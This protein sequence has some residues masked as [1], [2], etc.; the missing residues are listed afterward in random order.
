[1]R[2]LAIQLALLPRLYFTVDQILFGI[3]NILIY[4]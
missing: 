4:L 1:M 2:M 3:N